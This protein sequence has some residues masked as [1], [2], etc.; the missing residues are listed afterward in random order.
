MSHAP[1]LFHPRIYQTTRV[2]MDGN[3][4]PPPFFPPA[5]KLRSSIWGDVLCIYMNWYRTKHIGGSTLHR[6]RTTEREHPLLQPPYKEGIT[7]FPQDH[8]LSKQNNHPID[9]HQFG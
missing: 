2:H 9:T 3:T 5:P 7:F 6:V 8:N 4:T 1:V